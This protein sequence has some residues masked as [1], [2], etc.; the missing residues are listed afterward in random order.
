MKTR[1]ENV[2]DR[3]AKEFNYWRLRLAAEYCLTTSSHILIT[4]AAIL[5]AASLREQ[6]D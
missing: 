5:A 2:R 4:P 1:E 6:E 3:V